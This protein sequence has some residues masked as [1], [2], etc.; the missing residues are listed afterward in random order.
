MAVIYYLSA[1]PAAV[2]DELSTRIAEAIVQKVDQVAPQM[3]F[4]I[5][6]LNHLVRKHAHFLAYLILGML[7]IHTLRRFGIHRYR[8]AG[9]TLLICVLY[10]ISDEVHQ[11]F[12]P[13]RGPG[14]KDVLIDSSGAIVGIGVY[15]M[16][17]YV[18]RGR[19]TIE[20]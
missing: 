9:L 19:S 6:S 20:A 15:L 3:E 12:V 1:Q 11:M 10:A 18:V 5:R 4:D 14:L 8:G 7:V 16:V 13:G 2:S 17:L